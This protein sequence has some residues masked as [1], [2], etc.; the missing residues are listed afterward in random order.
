MK[1]LYDT[2]EKEIIGIKKV[3]LLKNI[4]IP[5]HT[6]RNLPGK[7]AGRKPISLR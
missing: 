2:Y 5:H 4:N 7:S 3:S 1:W 6:K